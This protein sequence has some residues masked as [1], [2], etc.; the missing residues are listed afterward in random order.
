M[1]LEGI[2]HIR[3]L[4][5]QSQSIDQNIM[6]LDISQG[7]N[8]IM[9]AIQQWFTLVLSLV[10]AGLAIT[11]LSL[12][13]AFKASTT[14]GQIGLALTVILSISSILTSL[15]ESWTSLETSL[16]AISRIK[17]LEENLLPEDKEG[18]GFEPS[19]EWPNKGAIEFHDVV[20]AYKYALFFSY[21]YF[22]L[23]DEINFLQSRDNRS[24]RYFC[25]N[26]TRPESRNLWSNRKVNLLS[27]I[28]PS[29]NTDT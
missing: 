11:V 9:H 5:W 15:M 18:E 6:K 24:E 1:Q 14:G 7:P 27:P 21:F 20:A 17:T 16:G 4:G 3:A 28:T 26:L 10:I 13:V 2:A 12:A 19:L 22:I 29:L 23:L 8:Y 25:E